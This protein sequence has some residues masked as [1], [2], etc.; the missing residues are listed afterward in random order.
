MAYITPTD[1]TN[2]IDV[3]NLNAMV[4]DY[5]QGGNALQSATMINICQLASD[6]ADALVASIY[7]TPFNPVPK[8]IKAA[9][10]VF[11]AEMLYQRRLTPDEKNPFKAQADMYRNLLVKIGAG[12]LPLDQ[13]TVRAFTPIPTSVSYMRANTNFF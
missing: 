7:V 10:I 8:K 1:I 12:E 4:D 2:V 9:T 3:V 6:N 11:A 13:G 5:A